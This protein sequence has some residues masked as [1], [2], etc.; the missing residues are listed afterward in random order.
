MNRAAVIAGLLAL[1]LLA[2]GY[3][4]ALF[5]GL[6]LGVAG[7]IAFTVVLFALLFFRRTIVAAT[8]ARRL[9]IAIVSLT[10]VKVAL[11]LAAP[12]PGWL[13]QQYESDGFQGPAQ[14]STEFGIPG[15]TRIDARIEFADDYLPVHFL[16]DAHHNSGMRREVT[17]PLSIRWT[18][19]IK[20][21]RSATRTITLTAR[22]AATLLLDTAALIWV[23]PSREP[24][25]ITKEVTFTPGY[26]LLT[27]GYVKPADTDPLIVLRGFEDPGVGDMLVTPAPADTGA[28]HLARSAQQVATMLDAGALAAGVAFGWLLFIT[29]RRPPAPARSPIGWRALVQP[30]P[31]A[32]AMFVL[33]IAQ[34]AY[35]SWEHIGRAETLTGGDDW[36][37]YE[38][39]AR[40]VVTGGLLMDFGAPRGRGEVFV[41]YPFY[42]YFVAAVH[43]IGG[44]DLF[45]PIFAHWV[46]L[47][48]TN[49]VVYRV[50]RRLFGPRAALAA[51]AAL[52]VIEQ[53]AFVRHY[54]VQLLSE[55]L[56]FLTV[57]LTV[58][59]LVRFADAG[60]R[61]DLVWT[62]IAGGVSSLTRPAM[63]AYLPLAAAIAIVASRKQ[64]K[65]P[66]RAI[67]AASLLAVSWMAVVS[68]ATIR[69]YVVAGSPVLITEGQ[70]RSFV[71][72]NLPGT[73]DA[74][75]RYLGVHRGTLTSTAAILFR[76]MVE[77]PRRF[78]TNVA[79]KVGFSFGALELMGQRH[80]P[81]LI[82]ASLGYLAAIVLLPSARA[83]RTWPIHAFV[84]S[85]LAGMVLSMPSIYGYRLILPM[86]IFF[87]LF[88]AALVDD[89]LGSPGHASLAVAAGQEAY[90]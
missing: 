89:G 21:E 79:I 27:F 5:H 52:V 56:Y 55:N 25:S 38:A 15:A 51:V 58:D 36:T 59:R 28:R 62:G 88:G 2:P 19:Y 81:E 90:R 6:P 77:E 67:A 85:H 48:A 26:H 50:G 46:L 70:A 65:G 68:L 66:S 10:V 4:T 22:G 76:I 35:K 75:D 74:M 71:M 63:M 11:A 47:V 53:L 43:E 29:A 73:P 34:G 3:P 16:N 24:V 42:S 40:E 32:A 80:H 82:L 13:S 57:A 31:L 87:P 39:R 37:A 44:E 9:A 86:Y 12:R 49:V 20:P 41:Y 64:R 1:Y 61:A 83:L 17:I 60:R 54:S 72:H 14:A 8:P 78:F 18:G 84:L 7:L 69:N 45:A 23:G 33:F 30:R